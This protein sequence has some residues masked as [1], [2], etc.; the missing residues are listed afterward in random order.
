MA[1]DIF[2][3]GREAFAKMLWVLLYGVEFRRRKICEM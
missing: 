2:V 3:Q 1:G